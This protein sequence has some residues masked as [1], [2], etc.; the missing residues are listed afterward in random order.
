MNINNIY[1][2]N[3]EEMLAFIIKN[4]PLCNKINA[5]I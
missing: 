3:I 4:L 5:K 2:I 1:Y